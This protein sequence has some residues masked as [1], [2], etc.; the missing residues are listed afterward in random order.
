MTPRP[1]LSP[2]HVRSVSTAAV[3]VQPL[4]PCTIPSNKAEEISGT[5]LGSPLRELGFSLEGSRGPR[6]FNTAWHDLICTD[7]NVQSIYVRERS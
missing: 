5:R 7:T 4:Q 1:F 3:L 6:V 2:G